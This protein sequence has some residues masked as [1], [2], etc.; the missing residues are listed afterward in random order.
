MVCK[1]LV[2]IRANYYI[3]YYVYTGDDERK[4][5]NRKRFINK[6]KNGREAQVVSASSINDL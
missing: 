3:V 5:N 4:I 6:W 1:F 2:V